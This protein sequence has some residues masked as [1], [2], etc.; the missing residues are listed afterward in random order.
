[1]LGALRD[2]I[3][4]VGSCQQYLQIESH[5]CK[6]LADYSPALKLNVDEIFS[7]K[8]KTREFLT[9]KS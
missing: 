6:L 7:P 9:V 3:Y 4:E 2:Q 5:Y 1:M 8:K